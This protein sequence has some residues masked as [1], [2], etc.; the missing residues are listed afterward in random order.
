MFRNSIS[1]YTAVA[2]A[3]HWAIALLI[4]FMIWLGWNMEDNEGRYQ[5][6]KSIGITILVLTVARVAWRVLNPPPDLPS[7]I[8][9]IEKIASHYV[10]LALYALMI[11]IPLLGWALVS[12]SKLQVPTVLFGT[13]SWPDLPFLSGL[14]G[15]KLA[16][17]VIETLHSKGAWVIIGLLVLHVGGALKH[18]FSSEEGVLK[19]MIPG[20]FGKTQPPRAPARGFF[21]AFGGAALL[22]ALIAAV[23]VLAQSRTASDT[24]PG[25]DTAA[26]V[27][28]PAFETNWVVDY[29]KSEIRFSGVHDGKAF[30]GTFKNWTADVAFFP[31]AVETSEVRVE[32]Q[33]GT[34]ATGKKLYDDSLRAPE[35]FDVSN[36]PSATVVLSGFA[37]T[38][39]GYAATATMRLKKR[40]VTT[41]LTF[42]LDIKDNVATLNGVA[43]FDRKA[44]GIGQISDPNAEWVSDDVTVT[45]TGEAT[46]K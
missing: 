23:P 19:R 9:P 35:W 15:N 11:L 41:P 31:N 37:K 43:K 21:I 7:S 5:P 40:T 22:F 10:H 46:R 39:T 18:E 12:T 26:A 29:S 4:I 33:T 17:G 44:L 30:S 28:P 16:H 6:H 13:V 2:I 8:K 25:T 45:V 32:V 20:L 42:T 27:A 1:R 14:R 38:E 34:A 36:F 24:P 3:L